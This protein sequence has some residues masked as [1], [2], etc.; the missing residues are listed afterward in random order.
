MRPMPGYRRLRGYPETADD[1]TMVVVEIR[2]VGCWQA[3]NKSRGENDRILDISALPGRGVTVTRLSKAKYKA[4]FDAESLVALR[5][6]ESG[7]LLK[8]K[9][10]E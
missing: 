6:E 5:L 8:K 1:D 10:I 4:Q 7:M 3:L 9:K 2:A